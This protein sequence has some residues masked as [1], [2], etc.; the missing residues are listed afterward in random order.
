M[1]TD[2]LAHLAPT[3]VIHR[4]TSDTA[5]SVWQ[6]DLSEP[7]LFTRVQDCASGS[8]AK[9][10]RLISVG[11]YM[12]QYDIST[13][14]GAN[15]YVDYELFQ[16]DPTVQDPLNTVTS[17]KGK[18]AKHKFWQW[19][20][21]YT[22]D[23][24][25]FNFVQ[26]VPF[27]GYV[28]IYMPTEARGSYQLWNFDPNPNAPNATDP[29]PNPT[30]PQD[31]F[32]LIGKGSEIIPVG[33]YALEWVAESCTYRVWS[34]DPQAAHPLE[35]PYQSTGT[36]PEIDKSHRLMALGEMIL[37]WV[38]ETGAY[39]LWGFNPREDDPFVGPLKSG[40]LPSEFD[41]MTLLTPV[42]THVPVDEDKAAI[43][44]TMDYMR[45]NVE[46][47]VVYML[48]SRT[49]DSVLG[50]LYEKDAPALHFVDADPPFRGNSTGN[51]NLGPKGKPYAPYLFQDGQLSADFVLAAPGIDP[52][53]STSDSIRQQWS[54][55]YT[56]YFAG[57]PC[58]Q[59][60][61]VTS[62]DSPEP[63]VTFS[64]EQLPVL[65]GL[66][67]AYGVS[68][69]W[70][71]PMPGG[72]TANRAFA[73]TGSNEN[74]IVN[75]EG[76]PDYTNFAAVSRR[77][78]IWKVLQNNGIDDWKIYY[79]ILWGGH[80]FTEYLYLRG[81]LPSVDA[82]PSQYVQVQDCFWS[83]AAAGMLPK[84]SF[85]EPAWIAPT[86]ATSYHPGATGDMVPGEVVLN[87]VYE[88]LRNSP[89]WEK[90]ALVITFSK[91]GGL[92]DHIPPGEATP[93]WP[94]DEIDGFKYDV[95]GPR[96]PAIVVS[97]LVQENTVFRSPE[98]VPFSATS[99]AATVLEWCGIPRARWGMGD[100]VPES[101]VFSNVFT[102]S[103]PRTDTP[104]FTPPYDQ[105]YLSDGTLRKPPK[106]G[107]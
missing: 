12:L 15:G 16:F 88:A 61:Y 50:W 105:T 57:D 79:Q 47:V 36:K 42:Q 92:Y 19:Y 14:G 33:N 84:F 27:N 94:K 102:L 103:T 48:E 18:W 107:D 46:H 73:L 75:L 39:T 76:E 44:G 41:V 24:N 66:A 1:T 52:F 9:T 64:P 54:N 55:G 4:N 59:G 97:P 91:G 56:G 65:N 80:V 23:P 30:G 90:T 101:P 5:Y 31:A 85:L 10:A 6:M 17:Q 60:G 96:V 82:D 40:K 104:T 38:P 8:V 7:E 32:S 87:Q 68:D 49:M 25:D 99:I 35:L 106:V 51:T 81:Q 86:G 78:S 13:L 95:F 89:N 58:D 29:L 34:F 63:M 70:F 37:D 43:P 2:P 72:T 62:S 74:V 67:K 20:S 69:E 22:W 93:A 28:M 53:H 26:M 3:Y 71:S 77:Q 21:R 98:A 83:D 45:A 11:A 100:R